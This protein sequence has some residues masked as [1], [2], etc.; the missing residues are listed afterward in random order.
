MCGF[1]GYSN[2][3]RHVENQVMINMLKTIEY[4]GPD[5][6]G[7]Y[8]TTSCPYVGLGHNRLS[9]L[10]L[11]NQ[12]HQPYEYK[13]LII[14]YNGEIYNHLTIRS[15]LIENGY[16]FNSSCDTETII[17]AIHYWGIDAIKR[18]IGMFAIAIYDKEKSELILVRDRIG[19]KPLYYYFD[20][21]HFIFASE[22]KPIMEYPYFNKNINLDVLYEYIFHG[23]ISAP[24]TIFKNTYKLEPGSY[25]VFS[26]N[27]IKIHS[28][29]KTLNEPIIN[30][31]NLIDNP[32]NRYI[33]ELEQLIITSVK[34]RMIS[35]VPIGTF[36]SGGY[37]SSLISSI[38]QELSNKPI[39]TFSIGFDEDN[40]NEAGYAKEVASYLGTNHHEEYMP[41]KEAQ[42]LI[43][44]I[45]IYY[46]EPFADSSQ[47]PTLLVSH[48]ARKSVKVI[49]SGDGGDEVF[50]GY[51]RYD[52]VSRYSKLVSLGKI[53]NLTSKV[54]PI[55]Y[56]LPYLS[57]KW[58]K[59]PYLSNN[60]DIINC[61]YLGSKFH[62][63]NLLLDR[64][65]SI[66]TKY[67]HA[68]EYSKNIQEAHMIQDMLTYLPDD[69]LCKVDRASMSESL[70]T[71]VPLLDHRIIE[72]AR[73]IPHTLK[74]NNGE[75]KYI[76]KQIAHK[77]I[78]KKLLDRPKQ[79]FGIPIYLWLRTDMAYLI[80]E[81]L[82]KSIINKQ[83]IFNYVIIEKLV[84]QF[85]ISKSD[86]YARFIWH[87]IVFQ[88]WY[89]KYYS[90]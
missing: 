87:L 33:D 52:L 76:L 18:F 57:P 59:T 88:L 73:N 6:S 55:N 17:K 40:Y 86:Y 22:L 37:D 11:S 74:Y 85:N 71:R 53:F 39:N 23:Y 49:L 7:I 64:K 13:N 19:I 16:S 25:L 5:D 84:K 79:G 3:I 67:I 78:P 68:S 42:K 75:K 48:L 30:S 31:S 36:L 61:N 77:H 50:C 54:L 8:Y 70:E 63:E 27:N 41:I 10:D 51:N 69:I 2:S 24:N 29:W 89:K 90:I 72:Y 44:E 38:M 82:S 9:I 20:Q 81:N 15:S 62:I 35:D 28:Y 56:L 46:D 12:G 21:Q 47:L 58:S 65:F 80:E 66:N 14:V 32:K 83:G 4:R 26:N 43:E 1:T 45:P 60:T 34:D